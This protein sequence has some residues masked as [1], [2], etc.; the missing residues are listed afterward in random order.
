MADKVTS[1]KELKL[2]AK[3]ADNDTRTLTVD[4]PKDSLT[5]AQINAVGTIAKNS[6]VILGDKGA[7][8]FIR[9]ETAK[10][11]EKETTQLDLR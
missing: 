1:V 6:N 5:A 11:T 4:N 8:D 3:F 9:F 2:V 10:V 7:A